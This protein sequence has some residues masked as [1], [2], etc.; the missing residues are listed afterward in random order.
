MRTLSD[1]EINLVAGGEVPAPGP[2]DVQ[3][4]T[5]LAGDIWGSGGPTYASQ[6]T[7]DAYEAW[8][9]AGN[10]PFDFI[11]PGGQAN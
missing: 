5:G 2:N 4:G 10:N 9:A 11:W 6:A 7:K 8:V 3:T 1:Q